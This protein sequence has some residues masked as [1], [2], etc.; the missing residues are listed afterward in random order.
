[1]FKAFRTPLSD[2]KDK[3]VPLKADKG[4]TVKANE[5]FI[6]KAMDPKTT[7]ERFGYESVGEM[8]KAFRTPLSDIKDKRFT[9]KADKGFTVKADEGA[10]KVDK[11]FVK[12]KNLKKFMSN[13]I[14]GLNKAE[15]E[16][17]IGKQATIRLKAKNSRLVRKD[18]Q[19]PSVLS[20]EYG[21]N[22]LDE[23]IKDLAQRESR[24]DQVKEIVLQKERSHYLDFTSRDFFLDEKTKVLDKSMKA[25]GKFIQEKAGVELDIPGK[26]YKKIVDAKFAG[27]QVKE[28]TRTDRH[29]DSMRKSLRKRDKAIKQGKFKEAAKFHEQARLG[30]EFAKRSNQIRKDQTELKNLVK[31]SGRSKGKIEFDYWKNIMSL[32]NKFGFKRG[33]EPQ[34]VIPFQELL[35]AQTSLIDSGVKFRSWIMD[36]QNKSFK[37]LTVNQFEELKVL[38]DVLNHIGRKIRKDETVLSKQKLAEVK[39]GL[40]DQTSSLPPRKI[41]DSDTAWGKLNNFGRSI[42]SE[43]NTISH[44]TTRL[45]GFTEIIPRGKVGPWSSQITEPLYKADS[46]YLRLNSE[47]SAKMKDSLD[48]LTRSFAE[49]PNVISSITVPIP[50]TLRIR[51]RTWRFER[52]LMIAFNMGN[53]QNIQAV[54][55]G[56]GLSDS[57]LNNILAVLTEADWNAIQE[58]GDILGEYREELF[59]T[60][61]RITGFPPTTV[62]PD[63]FVTPSGQKLKGWYF[64]L[65]RDSSSVSRKQGIDFDKRFRETE[66]AAISDGPTQERKGFGG[67]PVKLSL[68]V[69]SQ[70]VEF[71]ALYLSHAETVKDISKIFEDKKLSE[72][73]VEKI[74]EQALE[75]MRDS[76]KN[77]ARA[78]FE[79]LS[80][81]DILA[82]RVRGMG[83]VHSLGMKIATA[84]KQIFSIPLF[85]SRYGVDAYYLGVKKVMHSIFT[86]GIGELIQEVYRLSP[87]MKSRSDN[88][89]VQINEAVKRGLLEKPFA[90]G[91]KKSQIYAALFILIRAVDSIAVFPCW[92]GAFEDGKRQF[93]GD[94]AKATAYA[95]KSIRT[96]QPSFRPI[97]LSPIQHSRKGIARAF[98]F[99][100]TFTLLYG[101]NKRAMYTALTKGQ[102]S[103]GQFLRSFSLESIVPPLA[104]T[105]TFAAFRGDIPE[106]KEILGDLFSYN[107]SGI[108]LVKDFGFLIGSKIKGGYSPDSWSSPLFT[109]LVM[110]WDLIDYIFRLIQDLDD[111]KLWKRTVMGLTELV[112]FIAKV[113]VPRMARDVIKGMEQWERGEGTFINVLIPQTPNKK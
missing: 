41:T 109:P 78:K 84:V 12:A 56:Y 87:Y 55:E 7:A 101:R 64:P 33:K 48:Q 82:E 66:A 107:L 96:T 36:E 110:A 44:Y 99:F 53:R 98:T 5:G 67:N 28:A 18:G 102:M 88:L 113:P 22:S 37:D 54:K 93:N 39:Q 24:N 11:E 25:L 61:K 63:V 51:G 100:S 29:L 111:D 80:T 10:V 6:G 13:I 73:I 31:K 20:L 103:P 21:Y 46:E 57:D 52:V 26:E 2:I 58:I 74:G 4:F 38:F 106:I 45:D 71:I 97:D 83:T 59:A 85:W 81:L 105:F 23:M 30:Y 68:S 75:S 49:N 50:E 60:K 89:D 77:I 94:V 69:L 86:G 47:I 76:L 62:K 34:K 14:L 1:M 17:Q 3:G 70:H 90:F 15:L 65:K 108:P 95:D 19:S 40:V 42:L 32:G 79:V 91:V 9:F 35:D 8:F 104:M 92:L 43:L 16:F 112:S 72:L 27:V